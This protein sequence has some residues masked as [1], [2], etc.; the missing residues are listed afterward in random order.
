MLGEHEAASDASLGNIVWVEDP[1]EEIK[2]GDMAN[3]LQDQRDRGAS[4]WI[5]I[6]CS[7]R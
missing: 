7:G 4:C 5:A 2:H 3:L 1:Y 6:L